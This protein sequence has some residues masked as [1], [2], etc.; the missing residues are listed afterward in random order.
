MLKRKKR[1]ERRSGL[2]EGEEVE[3]GP[4]MGEP[5]EVEPVSDEEIGI[6]AEGEPQPTVETR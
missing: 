1:A 5:V 6:A 3:R 4:E 2:E